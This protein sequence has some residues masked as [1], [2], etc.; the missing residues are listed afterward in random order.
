MNA[1]RMADESSSEERQVIGEKVY[2][3]IARYLPEMAGKLT[4]MMMEKMD[5]CEL[6][7]LLDSELQ[8]KAKVD[9][10]FRVVIKAAPRSDQRQMV[11]EKLY[12]AIARDQPKVAG[13]LAGMILEKIGINELLT[14]LESEQEQRFENKV[15]EA[16]Q[17]LL[18]ATP[19]S[20]Q[21]EM[22]EEKISQIS[23]HPPDLTEQV[24]ATL[25]EMESG[26][27]LT[28]MG[29][30]ELLENKIDEIVEALE[31]SGATEPGRTTRRRHG[32]NRRGGAPGRRDLTRKLSSESKMSP[33]EVKEVVAARKG[34]VARERSEGAGSGN[35][36]PGAPAA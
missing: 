15:G 22:I 8:L 25:L 6:Q 19:V 4:G 2:A 3:A 7:K 34:G 36:M 9:E 21:R 30:P 16:F 35:C 26:E 12:H 31:A 29:S 17:V 32:K 27:L 11:G 20:E 24:M 33:D 23:F 10:A 18:A 5:N 28:I 13:K 1:A 14:L